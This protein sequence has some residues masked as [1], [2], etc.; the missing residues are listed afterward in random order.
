M[1]SLLPSKIWTKPD[2]ELAVI[3]LGLLT[4]VRVIGLHFSVVDLF[5]DESQY[6][7]WA[8]EPAF[9]YVSKPP[10]LA[11][12]IAATDHVCGNSE[13]CIRTPMPVFY[14]GTCLVVY[15]IA[16]ELYDA[17]IGFFAAI[18]LA[19][20]PGISFSSRIVSTDVPLLFFWTLALLAYVKLLTQRKWYWIV[21]LGVSLGLGL[22]AKYAMVYF[23]LGV[24]LAAWLEED[25]RRL[26]R[27]SDPWIAL[28]IAL[29]LLAPNIWW[30]AEH[31]FATVGEVGNNIK[32]DGLKFN[33]VRALEFVASQFGVLGVILFAVLLAAI[34]RFASPK[35]SRAD[36]L[37][38]AFAIPPL[39]LITAVAWITHANANWAATAFISGTIVATATLVQARAWKW[40]AASIAI[41]IV[42]QVLLLAGDPFAAR[43]HLPVVGDVYSRTMGWRSF[44]EQT[45]ALARSVG[46]RSIVTDIHFET[47]SLLY[48][49]RNQPERIFAWLNEPWP[50]DSFE[51][52]HPFTSDTPQPILYVTACFNKVPLG[53]YFRDVE[54]LGRIVAP[55]GPRTA[56]FFEAYKLDGLRGDIKPRGRCDW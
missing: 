17:R 23:V 10:L 7:A 25:A 21:L 14:F 22:L 40:L 4:A 49:W 54:P 11:W 55:S 56:H 1:T 20:A 27:R 24:A 52:N 44:A 41:G 16:S 29:L 13:A 8:Q 5:Y 26:W 48:Y 33:P 34:V 3:L 43:A 2:I 19:L 18:S 50:Q 46:A 6:W 30:N 36:R 45:G 51:L 53:D 47:A 31:H 12:I 28:L 32:G 9:G 37:M 35:M 42:A 39:A 15:A 38:L